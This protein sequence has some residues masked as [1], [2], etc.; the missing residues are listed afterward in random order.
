MKSLK[1]NSFKLFRDYDVNLLENLVVFH[2]YHM[3]TGLV[4]A[5]II[6]VTDL[7]P[8]SCLNTESLRENII[9]SSLQTNMFTVNKK[10]YKCLT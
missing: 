7:R 4:K 8:P 6:R 3:T 5:Q 9:T 2:C 10:S 1:E